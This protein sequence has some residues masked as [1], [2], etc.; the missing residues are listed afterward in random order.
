MTAIQN[1]RVISMSTFREAIRGSVLLAT[2]FISIALII[3]MLCF[4]LV[5]I[6][7][8][9]RVLKDF[10]LAATSLASVA[11]A[12][13]SGA[14]LLEKEIARK[15]IFNVLSKSVSRWHF[16]VGKFLGMFLT[17]S[18][19]TCIVGTVVTSL[20]WA[21]E[22][23]FDPLLLIGL[24]F[25]IFEI[26]IICAA[27]V[28][29]STIV[30]TPILAGFLTFGLFLAGRS[31]EF[32][33]Y[34]VERG[35]VTGPG[36]LTLK[37]LYYGLPNLAQ[38]NIAD[39]ITFGDSPSLQQFLLSLTYSISYSCLLVLLSCILFERRDFN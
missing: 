29:F 14:A 35:E 24:C 16:I 27:T 10:G 33:L 9:V 37:A 23:K 6:G 19:L 7:D 8:Q 38:L 4:G 25:Q 18:S 12:A 20:A 13:I 28:F 32:F 39:A 22:G 2:V 30:V 21:I 5:T 36:R 11:Y 34:F 17:A 3:I 26:S 1:I 31:S 15:T